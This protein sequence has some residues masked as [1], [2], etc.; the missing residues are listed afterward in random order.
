MAFVVSI[1]RGHDAS[2][3]FKTTGAAEGPVVTGQCG[4]GYYLSAVEQGGEPDGTRQ[5]GPEWA[6]RPASKGRA[7]TVFPEKGIA[8]VSSRRAQI[9]K[10]T[11]A[12]ADQYEKV[13][14]HALDQRA[15]AS[16][17]RFA[18]VMTRRAKA[19]GALDFTALLG[20]WERASR[21]AELESLRD[22]RGPYGTQHHAQA[23]PQERVLTYAQHS[24]VGRVARA[25]QGTHACARTRGRG[26]DFRAGARVARAAALLGADLGQL[27]TQLQAG[28]AGG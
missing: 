20:G 26:R 3:P 10:T 7:I 12:L 21:V 5:F 9:T 2:Y 22:S 28:A 15:M 18:N 14:G 27:Q 19:P 11:L 23:P 25:A 8:Q 24:R 6:Y 16:M 1:A 17:G 13:R 4:A